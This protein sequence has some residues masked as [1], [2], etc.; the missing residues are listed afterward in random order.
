MNKLLSFSQKHKYIRHVFSWSYNVWKVHR[1]Y[2]RA[3]RHWIGDTSSLSYLRMKH[4]RG[5]NITFYVDLWDDSHSDRHLWAETQHTPSPLLP[6]SVKP[7]TL[8]ILIPPSRSVNHQII[9]CSVKIKDL[10]SFNTTDWFLLFC[11]SLL[12]CVYQTVSVAN[13][14]GAQCRHAAIVA[15]SKIKWKRS[16]HCFGDV[17]HWLATI[18]FQAHWGFWSLDVLFHYR[19]PVWRTRLPDDALFLYG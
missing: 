8:Q 12:I 1:E 11:G 3:D 5:N 10:F 2:S 13:W 14:S 18:T 9:F 7:P 17:C 6:S 15:K 19:K 16:L 4:Q